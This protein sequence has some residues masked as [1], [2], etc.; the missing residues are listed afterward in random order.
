MKNNAL[1]IAIFFIVFAIFAAGCVQKAEEPSVEEPEEFVDTGV[2]FVDS[3]PTQAQVYVNGELKGDTPL[4]LYNLPVGAYDTVVKKEG[5]GD[6]QKTVVVKVGKT[7]EVYVELNQLAASKTTEGKKTEDVK[8]EEA[9]KNI[10][11]TQFNKINVSAFAMYHDFEKSLFTDV[12]T[13]KSDL[14][15]R[16]YDN[17]VHFTA[18]TP[19]KIGIIN[20]PLKD[21][22]KADCITAES[23]A[24]P[25]FSGQTLCVR[26]IEGS[27]I[28]IGWDKSPSELEWVLFS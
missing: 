1:N 3:T 12:R 6:S 2:L 25:V 20:K 26:T 4:T 24:L 28:A 21:V 19:A 16:K 5:Y 7:E 10:S 17:Y 27:S 23:G 22:D 11:A 14:F 18:I 8:L 9:P 13:D 15:S